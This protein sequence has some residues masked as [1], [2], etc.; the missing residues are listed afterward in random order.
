MSEVTMIMPMA[1][2]G[3]RFAKQGETL[4]KPLIDLF[5]K[6]FF[7]WA[8]L[9]ILEAL[10][11]ARLVYVVLQQHVVHFAIDHRIR[12][13]FP[14]AEIL[15]VPEVTSGALETALRG[16][17]LAT[18]GTP[19]LINDCD[20]AF[21]YSALPRAID[22]LRLGAAGFLSHFKSGNP[23]FSYAAYDVQENLIETAEKRVIG[24]RAIAGI[25]GF[26]D[27]ETL[28]Q[29]ADLYAANCP[30]PELYVSGIYNQIVAQSGRVLGFDLDAHLPFGTPEEVARIEQGVD[31]LEGLRK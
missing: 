30:Y 16:V 24:E 9:G 29:A 17:A 3:S 21:R 12:G 31:L 27:S 11:N 19:I 20:H 4:P 6:P 8:S 10:P 22:A 28:C 7:E 25:Y 1:G 26:R 14:Q 13:V 15:V 2:L 18:A 5:G 23:H